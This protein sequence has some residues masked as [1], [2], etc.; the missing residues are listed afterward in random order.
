[1]DY[2]LAVLTST[3]TGVLVLWNKNGRQENADQIAAIVRTVL[4][5]LAKI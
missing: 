4:G 1:M 5:D 2:H 3:M